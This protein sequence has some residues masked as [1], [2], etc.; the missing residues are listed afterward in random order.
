M[1]VKNCIVF[2]PVEKHLSL[3]VTLSSLYSYPLKRFC[4]KGDGGMCSG[5][6]NCTFV[7]S[8]KPN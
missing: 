3:S 5:I 8:M 2:S 7:K 6:L 4:V 1:R